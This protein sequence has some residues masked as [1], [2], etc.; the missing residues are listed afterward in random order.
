MLKLL[1]HDF[2]GCVLKRTESSSAKACHKIQCDGKSLNPVNPNVFR[3]VGL[4]K[5][6]FC[7]HQYHHH[8]HR[9]RHA[10]STAIQAYINK[11]YNVLHIMV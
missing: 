7:R 11:M 10:T 8:Q 5:E 2:H 1:D 9:T 3:S 6:I 4:E